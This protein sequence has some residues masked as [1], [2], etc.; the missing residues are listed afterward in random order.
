[1]TP[2]DK[3]VTAGSSCK[4]GEANEI[5]QNSRKGKLP[6]IN[7]AGELTA[8]ISRTDL[9]KNKDFPLASL[10]SRFAKTK[11]VYNKYIFNL[12]LNQKKTFTSWCCHRHTFGR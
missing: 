3:L 10:D 5:L 12:S 7:E 2:L 9:K 6:I 4:L 1:M 11:F 8:L